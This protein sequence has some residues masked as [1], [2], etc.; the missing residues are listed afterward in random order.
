MTPIPFHLQADTM[1]DMPRTH[2]TPGGKTMVQCRIDPANLKRLDEIAKT[3]PVKPSRSQMIDLA[4]S[5]YVERHSAKRTKE[6]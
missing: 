2:G 4:V 1:D 3:M 5:E 6:R